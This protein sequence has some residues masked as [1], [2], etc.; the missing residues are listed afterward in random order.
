LE[1]EISSACS[2]D[3]TF[4]TKSSLGSED[5]ANLA[6]GPRYIFAIFN[7]TLHILSTFW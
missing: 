4:H 3:F 6:C 2:G 7:L 1:A 5:I